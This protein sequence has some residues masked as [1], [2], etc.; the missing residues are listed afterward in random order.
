MFLYYISAGQEDYERMRP[1]V[2]QGISVDVFLACFSILR[3]QTF[4]N[5]RYRWIPEVIMLF[6]RFQVLKFVF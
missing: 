6:C 1:L 4:E 3:H 5:I 2:Y